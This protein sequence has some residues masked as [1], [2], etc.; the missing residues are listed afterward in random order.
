ML[1]QIK[2]MVLHY[3]DFYSS[4]HKKTDILCQCQRSKV[5]ASGSQY[6]IK[7]FLKS[8]SNVPFTWLNLPS[9]RWFWLAAQG[10]WL[11]MF[12]CSGEL[13][14]EGSS[15]EATQ[16]RSSLTA[17]V[18]SPDHILCFPCRVYWFLSSWFFF[19]LSLTQSG[20]KTAQTVGPQVLRCVKMMRCIIW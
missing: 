6:S 3:S 19:F 5:I 17:A 18:C 4:W 11:V 8:V 14:T 7:K 1:S 12:S 20:A 13:V 16:R 9:E 10:D 2:K 15:R